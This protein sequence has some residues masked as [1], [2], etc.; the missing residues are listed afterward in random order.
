MRIGVRN[1]SSCDIM[2]LGGVIVSSF[3]FGYYLLFLFYDL[4]FCSLQE[5]K[6]SQ[7]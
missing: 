3:V 7:K 2:N 5:N 1:C 4:F 6:N